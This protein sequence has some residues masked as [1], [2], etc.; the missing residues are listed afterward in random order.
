M[1]GSTVCFISHDRTTEF[2]YMYLPLSFLNIANFIFLALTANKI[3]NFSIAERSVYTQFD[4][5]KK[6]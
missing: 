6:R 2:I 4:A 3:L 5:E 1:I